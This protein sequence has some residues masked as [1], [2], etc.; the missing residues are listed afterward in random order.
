MLLR[1][2]LAEL[3]RRKDLTRA[4]PWFDSLN[5]PR[6]AAIEEL[7]RMGGVT[8]LP[9][10]VLAAMRDEHFD[11]AAELLHRHG[12]DGRFARLERQIATGAWQRIP[13]AGPVELSD[14]VT[15]D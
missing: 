6:R 15:N 9:T 7:A 1:H 8:N 5:D 10:D 12:P 13:Y 4:V 14:P 2:K 3:E 11:H